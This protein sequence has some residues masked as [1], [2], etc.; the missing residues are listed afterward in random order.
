MGRRRFNH[1]EAVRLYAGGIAQK[2]IAKRFGV[3]P[4]AISL[5]VGKP[6]KH[7]RTNEAQNKK[8]EEVLKS[9]ASIIS[10]SEDLRIPQNRVKA[11]SKKMTAVNLI[12]I[13][14]LLKE[15]PGLS[16]V[17]LAQKSGLSYATVLKY[18]KKL[19]DGGIVIRKV[20][21]RGPQ[22]ATMTQMVN[23]RKA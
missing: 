20:I 1:D 19:V 15:N 12:A 23:R 14:N 4:A 21:G 22:H 2:D 16:A 18:I 11:V 3:T 8:I 7:A 6:M 5:V 13:T 17:G 9:G 10:V